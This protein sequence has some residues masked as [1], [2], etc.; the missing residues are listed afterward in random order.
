MSIR[1]SNIVRSTNSSS[2]LGGAGAEDDTSGAACGRASGTGR[3]DSRRRCRT[4]GGMS[5]GRITRPGASTTML[6]TRLRSSRTFPGH[7]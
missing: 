2:G 1:R 6:S 5:S 7:S 3:S 4:S